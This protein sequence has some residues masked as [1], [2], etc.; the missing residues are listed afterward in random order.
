MFRTQRKLNEPAIPF[1]QCLEYLLRPGM[2]WVI[3]GK[4]T[5]SIEKFSVNF[6]AGPAE[7]DDI[8][9]RLNPRFQTRS[10][11][12]NARTNGA[13]R[14]DFEESTP[15]FPFE[16]YKSFRI[17][18]TCLADKFKIDVNGD[19][20]ANY[21]H[22]YD[23]H[24]ITHLNIDGQVDIDTVEFLYTGTDPNIQEPSV[25]YYN[26]TSMFTMKLD[27]HL[28]RGTEVIVRGMGRDVFGM[29]FHCGPSATDNYAFRFSPEFNAQRVVRNSMIG[30]V[31]NPHA[32]VITSF[33]PF[34]QKESFTL[35]C[36]CDNSKFV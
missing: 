8:A 24:Q 1:N 6:K 19:H 16:K 5:P 34:R 9:L 33:F 35:R 10:V 18:I 27:R 2:K 20:F 7:G 25:T 15:F 11:V 4:P 3:T 12:R 32:E 14:K 28:K 30:K 36:I 26:P 22:R 13:W 29:N 21:K 23:L 17:E 31:W